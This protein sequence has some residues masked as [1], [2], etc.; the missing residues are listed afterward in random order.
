MFFQWW[1]I[2]LLSL[3]RVR[4]AHI[5]GIFPLFYSQWLILSIANDVQFLNSELI[6]EFIFRDLIRHGVFPIDWTAIFLGD[7]SRY[8]VEN[9]YFRVYFCLVLYGNLIVYNDLT[10]IAFSRHFFKLVFPV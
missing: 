8:T 4:C 9:V 2:D 5:P 3:N 1:L 6:S 10:I 7:I